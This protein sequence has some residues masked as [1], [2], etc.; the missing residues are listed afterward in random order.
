M[1]DAAPAPPRAAQRAARTASRGVGPHGRRD[2]RRDG[3]QRDDRR[4]VAA[5]SAAWS[6]RTRCRDVWRTWWLGDS[7]GALVVVPLALAWCRPPRPRLDARRVA[8][9]GARCSSP[10][11][12]SASSRSARRARWPTS[13][14][15]RWS[16]RRCA[17]A[18]AAR[19]SPSRSR[20]GFDGLGHDPLRRPVR[21]RRRSRAA[22]SARSSTSRSPSLSALCL[23]AVVSE[24]ERFA[25]GASRRRARGWSRRPTPSAGG[26]STTSTTARSSGSARSPC[27]SGWPPSDARAAPERRRGPML[28]EAERRGRARDRRAARARPRHPPGGAHRPRPRARDP[29]AS[30]RARRCRS[31]SSSCRRPPRRT[32]E[33]TAYYVFAEAVTNA[34]QHAGATVDLRPRPPVPARP[35]RRGRRR[36][37]RRRGRGGGLAGSEGLRDRVEALGGTFAVEVPPRARHARRRG[38]SG[39]DGRALERLPGKDSNLEYQGQ[40]LA[41][42]RLHHPAREARRRI[43]SAT[44]LDR[45][46]RAR[47]E[48]PLSGPSVRGR[49]STPR[50]D[51]S[52]IPRGVQRVHN[53]RAAPPRRITRSAAHVPHRRD[54]SNQRVLQLPGGVE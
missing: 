47:L 22:C 9:G 45:R 34:Q 46:A 5:R 31:R 13:S 43:A 7:A 24:R 20:S 15:R 44:L 12:G 4:A 32:V 16:G 21:L 54:V 36:R 26:S 25:A 52:P 3:G 29:R 6:P 33:A 27:G 10:S 51:G 37:R 17:S 39:G 41:C 42:C 18:R 40:N 23:A 2:R 38:D 28:E 30:P 14:S 50:L 8:R 11:P 53:G 49:T 48:R 1:A 35:A 19:R